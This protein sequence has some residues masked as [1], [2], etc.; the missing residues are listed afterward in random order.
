MKEI[1]P[2]TVLKNYLLDKTENYDEYISFR[3]AFG[4][5]Y[6]AILAVNYMIGV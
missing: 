1:V 2:E 4:Y 3:K 6:G 5:Q